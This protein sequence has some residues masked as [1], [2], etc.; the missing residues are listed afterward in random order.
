MK[1]SEEKLRGSLEINR[2]PPV[3]FRESDRPFFER[4]LVRTLPEMKISRVG[5]VNISADGI[6]FR[7]F[8]A[9]PSLT[10]SHYISPSGKKT[11]L[12]ERFKKKSISLNP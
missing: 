2:T 12:K 9:L 10:R 8:S 11:L 5:K 1:I 4:D 7:G 3:N 6:L